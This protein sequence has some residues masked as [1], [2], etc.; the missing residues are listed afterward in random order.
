MPTEKIEFKGSSIDQLVRQMQEQGATP[1]KYHVDIY[2]GEERIGYGL[3]KQYE[4]AL[5]AAVESISLELPLEIARAS[6]QY[7]YEITVEAQ[8]PSTEG[9]R[10]SGS[11]PAENK[12]PTYTGLF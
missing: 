7:R 12:T 9:A 2:Y 11:A 1:E 3:A 6:K 4:P 8:K 10:P 5:H